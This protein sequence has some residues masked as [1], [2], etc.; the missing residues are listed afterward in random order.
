[1]YIIRIGI[2]RRFF[3]LICQNKYKNATIYFYFYYYNKCKA[4]T[5]NVIDRGEHAIYIVYYNNNSISI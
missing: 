4:S 5:A 1:M 3:F 2:C